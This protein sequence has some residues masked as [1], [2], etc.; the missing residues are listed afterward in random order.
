M[1]V[2]GKWVTRDGLINNAECLIKAINCIGS[3]V[4]VDA[5]NLHI[6]SLYDF[7]DIPVDGFLFDL[8]V[9]EALQPRFSDPGSELVPSALHDPVQ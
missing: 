1:A 8:Y 9:S 5:M 4:S 6:K 2:L 7:M 3:R